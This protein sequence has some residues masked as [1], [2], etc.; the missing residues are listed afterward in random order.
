MRLE[1][2]APSQVQGTDNTASTS[3]EILAPGFEL[4]T[5]VSEALHRKMGEDVIIIHQGEVRR[6]QG[7]ASGLW[8]L[9]G[10]EQ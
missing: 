1:R 4:Q 9:K 2:R 10:R 7:T 5:E 8:T 3:Q 6:Q